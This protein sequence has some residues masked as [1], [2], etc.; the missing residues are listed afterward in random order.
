M[1]KKIIGILGGMGPEATA[2]LF[3]SIIKQT[4]ADKDQDHI[5]VVIDCNPSIPD[6]TAAILG[7]GPI[8]TDAII[9][10]GKGL[11]HVGPT[12]AGMPCITAHYFYEDIQKSLSYP[13]LNILQVL[14]KKINDEYPLTK[15]IGILATTGSIQTKIFNN[16]FSSYEIIYPQYSTQEQKV[17]KA[18]YGVNGI[19]KGNLGDIPRSLLIE[20]GLEL[21]DQG[22]ELLIA[23][24]TEIPLVLKAEHFSVPL[25]DPVYI[26]ADALIKYY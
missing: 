17:M 6:R 26:L 13:L 14:R 19:K 8:P 21:I 22:A 5:R 16:Y 10:T 1:Q 24:C 25:L 4:K 20:A 3:T 7:K 9:M 12:V 11:E 23:G 2:Y 15:R 18:I